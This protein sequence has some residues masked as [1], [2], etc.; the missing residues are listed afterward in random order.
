LPEPT[1]ARRAANVDRV[2]EDGRKASVAPTYWPVTGLVP[3][4]PVQ[5][6]TCSTRRAL[7]LTTANSG[8]QP[9]E[10]F[11]PARP[12]TGSTSLKRC[13]AGDSGNVYRQGRA[14]VRGHGA[15]HPV[16]GRVCVRADNDDVLP[17][18]EQLAETAS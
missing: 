1:L 13:R 5:S 16:D 6:I 2:G 10:P 11:T 15:V 18:I 8:D 12:D 9:L 7:S 17:H 4:P 14:A 3:V